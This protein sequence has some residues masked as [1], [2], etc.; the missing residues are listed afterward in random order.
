MYSFNFQVINDTCKFFV[1]TLKKHLDE[2]NF[3]FETNLSLNQSQT[4]PI[5]KV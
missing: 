1:Q 2:L 5:S 3:Y 4:D